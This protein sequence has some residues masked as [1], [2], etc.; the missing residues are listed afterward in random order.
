[1]RNM[2]KGQQEHSPNSNPSPSHNPNP[3]PSHKPSPSPDPPPPDPATP[4]PGVFSDSHMFS[5]IR[6]G[7]LLTYLKPP[8]WVFKT[9]SRAPPGY[10]GGQHGA[11]TPCG[12][13]S[14][15]TVCLT[16]QD[17]APLACP[18]PCIS[19]TP[20]SRKA[21]KCTALLAPA[22]LCLTPLFLLFNL[23]KWFCDAH[24]HL[25]RQPSGAVCPTSPQRVVGC[26]YPGRTVLPALPVKT[27]PPTHTAR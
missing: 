13:R 11:H 7:L 26:P 23:S 17:P 24:L 18:T 16:S 3:S 27:P 21:H 19:H 20:G 12:T 2:R 1:M 10:S 5:M 9:L 22:S 25:H 6:C 8:G 15:R 4:C 14:P